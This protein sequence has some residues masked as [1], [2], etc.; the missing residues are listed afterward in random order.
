MEHFKILYENLLTT[1]PQ[2]IIM[3][4]IG[5]ILIFLAIKKEMEPS[6]LLPMGFGAILCNLPN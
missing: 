5:G 6:L 2:Q 4:V 1:T 3:W